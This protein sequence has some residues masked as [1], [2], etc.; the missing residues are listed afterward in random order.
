MVEGARLAYDAVLSGAV[1]T[2][3]FIT[4]KAHEKYP[5][6]C[7]SIEKTGRRVYEVSPAVAGV[8]SDTQNSQGIFCIVK[9]PP[10]DFEL[11][12]INT[13]GKYLALE[14]I[15]D[16]G[17]LGTM[18]RT[19]EAMG[20]DGVLLS[21]GCVD[22]FSPKVVR[23][24]M[25]AVFR[26]SFFTG[27]DMPNTVS[28]LVSKGMKVYAAVADGGEDILKTDFC[29]GVAAVIGNEGNGLT[30][31]CVNACTGK[32]T[33]NMRGRAESLNAAAAAT[34]IIWEITKNL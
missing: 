15:Q 4:A 18:L 3:S 30:R 1:I 31:E 10:S 34:V 33:I 27:L 23:A 28:R 13:K 21:S 26:L 7:R 6:C 8:L 16:P 24:S 12:Q 19:A 5:D 32:I 14:N 25:G 9:K 29:G 2:D 20:I 22:V 17:N 11:E